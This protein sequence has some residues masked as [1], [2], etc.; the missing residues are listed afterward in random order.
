MS[1]TLRLFR[2]NYLETPYVTP[3]GA[4]VAELLEIPEITFRSVSRSLSYATA[5]GREWTASP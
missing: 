2:S 4:K 3:G 5:L 1:K